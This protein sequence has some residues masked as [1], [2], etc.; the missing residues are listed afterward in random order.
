[1]NNRV[2]IVGGGASGVF[3]SIFASKNCDVTIFEKN[4]VLKTLLCTG[5][6]RCNLAY[7]E[8]DF[9]ELTKFYPRGNKFLYSIFS[10]FSTE[11]TI[12]FFKSI[13]VETYVQDDL[14]VFPKSDSAKEVRKALISTLM[15]CNVK[16]VNEEIK[17]AQKC[18]E[19]FILNDAYEFDKLIIAIGGHSGY[20][21][22]KI[23]GH[24]IIE[25]KPAL[26]G[27]KTLEQY[28]LQGVSLRN[29]EMK[30]EGKKDKLFGDI[31]FTSD[32][33]SGPLAYM[34]S[35]IFARENYSKDN[36]IRLSL[37]FLDENI[38]FS[39]VLNSNGKKE[40]KTIISEYIPKSLSSII[41]KDLSLEGIR[42]HEVKKEM[43]RKLE[44]YLRDF[45]LTIIGHDVKGEVVTCGGVD[46]KEINPKNMESKLVGNL[47]FCGEVI[48]VDGF[49]GGFNLQNA[50]SS[51]YVA[52]MSV[53]K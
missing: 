38:E 19:K 1:M 50:W 20:E 2:A 32:G 40:V 48:D 13:G 53:A 12:K 26:V 34:V 17:N 3:A 52:G 31:V 45:K 37:N 14:R 33:I 24:N 9:K 29:V 28:G 6:G 30:I 49:C 35:S 4:Y 7:N 36:P 43:R 18:G 10:K 47:Y 8:K 11:D 21:I 22:A 51:G 25:P 15:H 46:L 16:I 27:L 5:G 41:V 42:G 44:S 23:F 39:N